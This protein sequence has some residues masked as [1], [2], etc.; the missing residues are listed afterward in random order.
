MADQKITELA[1]LPGNPISTD[2][3]LAVRG[4]TDYQFNGT[5]LINFIN[6]LINAG[7]V[8]TFNDTLPANSSG[9]NGDVHI[10]PTPGVFNQRVAGVW[11]PQYTIPASTAGNTIIYGLTAP[12]NAT[13]A[14]GDTYIQTDG[15]IF[16]KKS[17][18]AWAQ[19]FSMATGPQGPTGEAGADGTDGTNGNGILNGATPPSNGLG[20]DGDY[21]INNNTK[22]FYGPKAAGVWPAG[23][24]LIVNNPS[25]KKRYQVT[26]SDA[27]FT[28]DALT[29]QLT[30]ALG[31]D[32]KVLFPFDPVYSTLQAKLEL[33]VA[34]DGLTFKSQNSFDYMI[35]NDSIYYQQVIFEGIPD[36]TDL[37]IT[38]N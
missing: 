25:F 10:Q 5:K 1:E 17:A 31:A 22:V 27:R 19:V 15:G 11:V 23:V 35:V 32:D 36:I 2:I 26:L 6:A 24:S 30:F 7:A 8:I 33:D 38:L 3:F 12:N 34:G 4:D 20:V 28:Y 18:G 37:Y 16:Y 21:Y 9:K 13:G 14:N 29:M